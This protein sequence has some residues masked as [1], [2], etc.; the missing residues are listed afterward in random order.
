M[1]LVNISRLVTTFWSG[2]YY[3]AD[4]MY[5]VHDLLWKSVLVAFA[6]LFWLVWI[7]YAV[8]KGESKVFK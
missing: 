8:K 1:H 4:V 3:G 7:E 2:Y 5:F 6:L